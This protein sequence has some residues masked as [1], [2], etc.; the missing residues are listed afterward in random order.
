MSHPRWDIN[1][2]DYSEATAL[3]Y[4]VNAGDVQAVRLLLAQPGIDLTIRTWAGQ[5]SSGWHGGWGAGKSALDLVDRL[6]FKASRE[7]CDEMR[8]LFG[9]PPLPPTSPPPSP[10]LEEQNKIANKMKMKK[11]AGAIVSLIALAGIIV[12]V[13]FGVF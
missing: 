2:Q 10:S 6:Q 4:A 13:K 7:L 12:G 11:V 9:M 8:E 3:I 1:K 5:C